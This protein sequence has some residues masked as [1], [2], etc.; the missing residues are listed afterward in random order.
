MIFAFS[1]I[2]ILPNFVE[3]LI[4]DWLLYILKENATAFYPF[5]FKKQ[6]LKLLLYLSFKVELLTYGLQVISFLI[7]KSIQTCK[8]YCEAIGLS[9]VL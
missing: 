3:V 8:S 2:K 7:L 1:L 4:L 9:L 6:T 5:Y